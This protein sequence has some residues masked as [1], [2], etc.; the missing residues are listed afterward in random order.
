MRINLFHF[1]SGV[2]SGKYNWRNISA[3]LRDVIAEDVIWDR[4]SSENYYKNA[5][6]S[7]EANY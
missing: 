2:A 7:T 5:D 3:S 6:G 4:E 1:F